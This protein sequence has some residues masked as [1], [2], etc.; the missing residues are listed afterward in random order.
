MANS[1]EHPNSAKEV[2]AFVA[3][4]AIALAWWLSDRN[5]Y[6]TC[7]VQNAPSIQN[8]V[9][10][11]AVI[12][13]CSKKY[14]GGY[15]GIGQGSSR[16]PVIGRYSSGAECAASLAGATPSLKAAVL[17]RIACDCLYDEPSY[18]GQTCGTI[19]YR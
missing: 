6:A 17:T 15:S 1:L 2:I 8:D 3:F 10:T 13:I 9:A 19:Y 12:Q 7:I 11:Y 4:L 14:P 18:S 5:N 16:L